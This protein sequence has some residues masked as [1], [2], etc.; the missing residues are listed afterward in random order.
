MAASVNNEALRHGAFFLLLAAVFSVSVG[1]GLI[2][3]ILPILPAFL[4]RLPL[5]ASRLSTAWLPGC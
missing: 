2:L 4:A 5:D 3:P 1:H